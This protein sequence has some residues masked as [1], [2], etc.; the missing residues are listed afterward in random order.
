VAEAD[1]LPPPELAVSRYVVVLLG[2][3]WRLPL[4]WTVPNPGSMLTD[5]ASFT[6]QRSVAACPRSMEPGSAENVATVGA[7]GGGASTFA[8]GGG[9]GGGGAAATGFFLH[10]AANI[11]KKTLSRRVAIFR[12]LNSVLQVQISFAP[13]RHLISALRSKLLDLCTVGQHGENLH[14]TLAIGREN[15][16]AARSGN[17]WASGS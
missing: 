15:Q 9:G 13:D 10:P 2:K 5:V 3:T 6:V 8:S 7:L 14:Q 16:V 1:A 12:L 17:R 11:I 4:L